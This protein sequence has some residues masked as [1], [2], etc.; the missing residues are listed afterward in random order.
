MALTVVNASLA[1]RFLRRTTHSAATLLRHADHQVEISYLVQLLF[2]QRL[3][4]FS[5]RVRSMRLRRRG[6]ADFL[7]RLESE[8]ASVP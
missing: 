1:P 6:E 7:A 8:L 5:H 2:Q 4:P 3:Y